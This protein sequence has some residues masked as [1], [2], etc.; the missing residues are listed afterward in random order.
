V[1]AFVNPAVRRDA[2]YRGIF[3]AAEYEAVDA[4]YDSQPTLQPTPLLELPALAMSLGLGGLI[5]KDESTRFGLSAFK[6]LGVRY[7]MGRI[8][9]AALSR[10]V[11]SATAGNHGRALAR[12]ARDL[13]VPCTVFVPELPPHAAPEERA[14][15]A[16]RVEGMVA[17]GARLIEVGG[18]YEAAVAR[19]AAHATATGAAI[20]SDTGWP[21]YESIPH[22]IMAGYT[23]LFSE[24]SRQW[25]I[26]PDMVIIQAGVGGLACAAAS[27]LAF[28]DGPAR[29]FLV[30]CEPDGSACLLESSRA[31]RASRLR[32]TPANATFMA[33]LR[34]SEPS[35]AAWPAV[36]DGADA[37]V[38]IP[39]AFAR[40]AIARLKPHVDAGPSGACG[41]GALLAIASEP[42]LADLRTACRMDESTRVLA[43]VSEGK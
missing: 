38:S 23:R 19:A 14:T 39:D 8:G 36:R 24:A 31:G 33:G 32:D 21:G 35:H 15:R 26:A 22:D 12:A 9:R 43:I 7:A 27:W 16:A 41:V 13:G 40:D 28:R 17:D 42:E 34:C 30:V 1:Q 25:T 29:P 18:T 11:V 20:V 6:A 2:A 3:S 10:G 37:F 5:V 4:F